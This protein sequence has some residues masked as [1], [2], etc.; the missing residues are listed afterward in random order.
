MFIPMWLA[1]GAQE[2]GWVIA[3]QPTGAAITKTE[4]DVDTST[5][6]TEL[7]PTN[8]DAVG[9]SVEAGKALG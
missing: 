9:S 7:A 4:P 1:R 3:G 6:T 5:V 2:N 8:A